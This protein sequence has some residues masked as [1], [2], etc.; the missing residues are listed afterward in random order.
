M[1]T[2][3]VAPVSASG[4]LLM[5]WSSP[6]ASLNWMWTSSEAFLTAKSE[7]LGSRS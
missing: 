5:T 4:R 1:K 7:E 2:C 6:V 3:A